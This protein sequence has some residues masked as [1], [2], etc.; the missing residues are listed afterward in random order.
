MSEPQ[1]RQ[2]AH[3]AAN[4]IQ[5][6][7]Q[8]PRGGQRKTQ[9]IGALNITS[10][11]NF[12]RVTPLAGTGV[13]QVDALAYLLYQI[14]VLELQSSGSRRMLLFEA[15]VVLDRG[16]AWLGQEEVLDRGGGAR[17]E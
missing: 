4:T 15:R 17:D 13:R 16:H 7:L 9:Y 11:Q 1:L 3:A 10:V 5:R 2:R 14:I 12:L 6:G 8:L